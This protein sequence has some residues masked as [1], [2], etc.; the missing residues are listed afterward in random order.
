MHCAS[1][2]LII[3]QAIEEL[4]TVKVTNISAKKNHLELQF[5]DPQKINILEEKI[6]NRIK[7]L[8]YIW[9][10]IPRRTLFSQDPTQWTIVILSLLVLGLISLIAK[11]QGW[12]ISDLTNNTGKGDMLF[13]PLLMGLVAGISSCM[14]LVGG[15]V[16]AITAKRNEQHQGLTSWQRFTPQL[17][18]QAGRIGGFIV[19]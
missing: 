16:L 14:A 11:D 18:F 5:T 15:L 6:A 8:G 4:P 19:F 1:C 2:E 9:G 12:S 17:I 10:D 7:K 13:F 3:T